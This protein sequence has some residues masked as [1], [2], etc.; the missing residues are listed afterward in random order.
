VR[1]R[2]QESLSLREGGRKLPP[3]SPMPRERIVGIVMEVLG[4]RVQV[5]E[6]GGGGANDDDSNGDRHPGPREAFDKAYVALQ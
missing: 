5:R 1:K 6:A 3:P 2:G 4:Y